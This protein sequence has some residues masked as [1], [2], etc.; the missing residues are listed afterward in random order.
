MDKEPVL[1]FTGIGAAVSTVLMMGLA[2]AVSLGWL[3]INQEQMAS[4]ENFVT[5]AIALAIMIAPPMVGAWFGKRQAE[6]HATG[7]QQAV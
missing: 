7:A 4:I 5:A 2:M 1:T 6:K 3:T